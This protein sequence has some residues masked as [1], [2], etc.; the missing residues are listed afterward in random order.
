V[1]NGGGPLGSDDAPSVAFIDVA[2]RKLLE[3]VSFSDPKINAGHLAL[4]RPRVGAGDKPVRDLAV[5]SAPRDGLPEKASLGGVTLRLGKRKP[6]EDEGFRRASPDAC[7]ANPSASASTSRT[8]LP[9]RRT[10]VA[11]RTVAVTNPHGDLVTF[12]DLDKKRLR[13]CLD[14][15]FPRGWSRLTLDRRFFVIT[16]GKEASMM[17]VDVRTLERAGKPFGE[18]VWLGIPYLQLASRSLNRCFAGSYRPKCPS[19]LPRGPT[20]F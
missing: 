2:S 8:S 11:P 3:R 17:L 7:S 12:W 9:R 20:W 16:F 19:F 4:S 6:E 1:T 10:R 13:T 15:I 14:A 5:S 18:G